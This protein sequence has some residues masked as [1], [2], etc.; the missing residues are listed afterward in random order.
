MPI[1]HERN[2]NH[3]QKKVP[4]MCGKAKS[5]ER[6]QELIL[7]E[8]IGSANEPRR[9]QDEQD[10]RTNIRHDLSAQTPNWGENGER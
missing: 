2:K 1:G 8:P 9:T 10:G 3:Q 7:V 6:Q 4:E 5:N